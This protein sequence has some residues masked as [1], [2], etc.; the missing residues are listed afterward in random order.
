MAFLMFFPPFFFNTRTD[1]QATPAWC[2][3]V[4]PN[5]APQTLPR[6][7]VSGGHGG[8]GAG[9]HVGHPRHTVHRRRFRLSGRNLVTCPAGWHGDMSTIRGSRHALLLPPPFFLFRRPIKLTITDKQTERQTDITD[10]QTADIT[11][12]QRQHKHDTDNVCLP[13]PAAA[14]RAA[15]SS[16]SSG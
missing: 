5:Q 7:L 13:P 14:L 11:D 6:C 16:S 2:A 3:R 9:V 4:Q 1:L 10:R 8:D 15:S 12:R